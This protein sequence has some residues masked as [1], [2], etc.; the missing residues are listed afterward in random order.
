MSPIA[1]S[2]KGTNEPAPAP[3]SADAGRERLA[4]Q[5][6]DRFAENSAVKK[7]LEGPM[8]IQ[9]DRQTPPLDPN[10]STTGSAAT[11]P[12]F[13]AARAGSATAAD[14]TTFSAAGVDPQVTQLGSYARNVDARLQQSIY[15]FEPKVTSEAAKINQRNQQKS[16]EAQSRITKLEQE[17][18]AIQ[19]NPKLSAKDKQSK[20]AEIDKKIAAARKDIHPQLDLKK[21][22][23]EIEKI[24][25]DSGLTDKQKKSRID[26]L[27]HQY[28]LGKKEMKRLFTGRL[29]GLYKNAKK[30]IDA[31]T[32]QLT[33]PLK[34][35]IQQLEKTYG[36]DSPQFSAAKARLDAL[37]RTGREAVQG[38]E[39]KA[40]LYGSM[41]K[42]FWSKVWGGLK[43][44]AKIFDVLSP[45]LNL[46]PGIGTALYAGYQGIKAAVYAGLG[47][48]KQMFGSLANGV[49]GLAGGGALGTIGRYAAKGF[50]GAM[51]LYNGVK[52]V[53]RDGITGIFGAIGG[54]AGS[55]GSFGDWGKVLTRVQQGAN[56][57]TAGI[58]IG[59]GIQT[60]DIGA[61]LGGVSGLS[62]AA[63]NL[64][65]LDKTVASRIQ[66]ISRY[67]GQGVQSVDAMIHG[68]VQRAL[69]S[70]GALASN[71]PPDKAAEVRNLLALGQNGAAVYDAIV[72]GNYGAAAEGFAGLLKGSGFPL[73][74]MV[75][76]QT[77]KRVLAGY[78]Y[79]REGW[80]LIQSAER[81]DVYGSIS[82]A[83]SIARSAGLPVDGIPVDRAIRTF[84]L[85]ADAYQAI[86]AGDLEGGLRAAQQI[87]RQSGVDFSSLIG[88][89]ARRLIS[90][91]GRYSGLGFR[92]AKSVIAR[93]I[94]G[95]WSAVGGAT[96]VL[97]PNGTRELAGKVL[98]GARIGYDLANA[99]Y[100][101][102]RGGTLSALDRS[103]QLAGVEDRSV[104]PSSVAA[105]SDDVVRWIDAAATAA[106][107]TAAVDEY[108][109]GYLAAARSDLDRS[110]RLATAEV[111]RWVRSGV[112][113]Q[114][115]CERAAMPDLMSQFRSLFRREGIL[116]TGLRW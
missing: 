10:F 107:S 28:G 79:A 81:G 69:G 9:P 110:A 112:R 68:D 23:S 92:M 42:S 56:A 108:V 86:A 114:E 97:A 54:A 38:Y 52:N 36:K 67:A 111:E 82:A 65:A 39:A 60:G 96:S 26:A 51:A 45:M 30:Q 15:Q 99:V 78:R 11:S 102:D 70:L 105:K 63:A 94:S 84:R 19:A 85:G 43:K 20:L 101:G 75:D 71:L 2:R 95:V 7:R 64:G 40:G 90:D 16:Q 48:F 8:K 3:W 116:L 47:K 24:S 13:A 49:L 55:F 12:E 87:V 44:V 88:A 98:D 6:D 72:K 91:A 113:V 103:F 80:Q 33:A 35:E 93:D 29:K 58:G 32:K 1:P 109:A 57:V 76:P 27:R 53:A 100:R 14:A 22:T 21:V 89:D 106:R 4:S 74:S 73:D 61:V 115:E 37:E 66:D 62:G 59:R 77:A 25:S 104:W 41:Y 83:G 46:I 50:Q 17:K 34:A 18:A 5:P 31:Q